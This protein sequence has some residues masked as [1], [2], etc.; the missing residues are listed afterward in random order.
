MSQVLVVDT[1]PHQNFKT[2]D[3]AVPVT[4]PSSL[5]PLVQSVQPG[6][7]KCFRAHNHHK[8]KPKC[9]QKVSNCDKAEFA[10][11]ERKS[12]KDCIIVK[13]LNYSYGAFNDSPKQIA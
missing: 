2:S 13:S 7:L 12:S 4:R 10:T 3:A 5:L 8:F 1:C 11:K 9:P 6:P